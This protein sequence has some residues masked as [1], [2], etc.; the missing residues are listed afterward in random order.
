MMRDPLDKVNLQE[1]N[2]D[3]DSNGAWANSD[4]GADP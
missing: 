3:H 2:D 4:T 1:V